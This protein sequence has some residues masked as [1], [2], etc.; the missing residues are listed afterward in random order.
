M[1][2]GAGDWTKIAIYWPPILMAVSVVSFSFSR[3]AQPEAQGPSSLLDDSFLY[4][5]LS[6]SP[7]LHRRSR[8][9]LRPGIAFP[10]TYCR[11]QR[12]SPTHQGLQGPLPPG[13]LYHTL[14]AT[15]LDPNSL[16]SCPHRVILLFNAHSIA[17]S[18]F[19]MA[20]LIVIK[21]HAVKR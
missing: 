13:F 20:C 8:G 3:A 5:T 12:W 11:H 15:A 6:L 17:H 14:S 4:C 2:V 9:P 16:T 1:W 21:R 10:T 7:K 19:G 18:I